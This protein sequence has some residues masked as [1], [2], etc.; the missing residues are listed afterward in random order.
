M[1]QLI[2]VGDKQIQNKLQLIQIV[3]KQIQFV[4]LLIQIIDDQIQ[5]VIL[6]IQIIYEKNTFLPPFRA[7]LGPSKGVVYLVNRFEGFLN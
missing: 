4:P 7:V 1:L 3:G 2:L 6:L 5:I